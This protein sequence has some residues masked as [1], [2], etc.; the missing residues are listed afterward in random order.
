MSEKGANE[1]KMC[2]AKHTLDAET[3][4]FVAEKLPPCFEEEKYNG[5]LNCKGMST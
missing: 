1:R 5:A 4:V 2:Y 3:A